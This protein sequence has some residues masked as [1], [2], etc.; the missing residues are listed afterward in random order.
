VVAATQDD[1]LQGILAGGAALILVL[2]IWMVLHHSKPGLKIDIGVRGWV[3]L[4]R[5][6]EDD[7]DDDEHHDGSAERDDRPDS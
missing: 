2:L 4:S 1:L 6:S 3:H 5:P 7:E